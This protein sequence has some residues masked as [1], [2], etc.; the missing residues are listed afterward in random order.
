LVQVLEKNAAAKAVTATIN[1]IVDNGEDF[2]R[3]RP[4]PGGSDVRSG[5]AVDPRPVKAHD[6]RPERL[7]ST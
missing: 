5:G 2:H 3:Q 6:G 1:Y 4:G 7:V